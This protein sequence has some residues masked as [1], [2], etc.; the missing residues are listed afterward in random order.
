VIQ[1]SLA[2]P[3]LSLSDGTP[4]QEDTAA[5]VEWEIVA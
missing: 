2:M 1:H 5:D 4:D 3:I